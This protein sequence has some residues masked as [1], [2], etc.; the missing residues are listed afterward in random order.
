MRMLRK[1]PADRFPS[2]REAA[3]AASGMR[4]SGGQSVGDDG[5]RSHIGLLA[6]PRLSRPAGDPRRTPSSPAPLPRVLPGPI[7]RPRRRRVQFS[8]VLVGLLLAGLGA[9]LTY[10]AIQARDEGLAVADTTPV[11]PPQVVTPPAPNPTEVRADSILLVVRGAAEFA[12]QRAV[13]SGAEPAALAVGD[14]LMLQAESLSAAGL[15]SEAS[16]L[17]HRAVSLWTTAERAKAQV[18]GGQTPTGARGVKPPP[19]GRP[20]SDGSPTGRTETYAPAPLP[21]SVQ[22]VEF[23]GELERA[24]ESRQLGEVK[25]LLP[26]LSE[27]ED[28]AW[29]SLFEDKGIDR[30]SA[31]FRVLAVNRGDGLTAYARVYEEIG[32][33]KGNNPLETKRKGVEYA[34]LTL[35]PQGWRQIQSEKVKP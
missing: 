26:N 31:T 4:I 30:I 33:A 18:A 27:T 34:T 32:T 22:I 14:S 23:Y 21:D 10:V 19:V 35:G 6:A 13:A 7:A 25:R 5:V 28:R 15:K 20:A 17:L 11:R 12:R 16:G 3:Q 29:R 24:V 1:S 2:V 9:G 8:Q